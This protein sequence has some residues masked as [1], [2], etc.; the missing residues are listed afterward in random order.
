MSLY[1]DLILTETGLVSYWPLY[2]TSGTSAADLK[3]TNTGT[4][5]GNTPDVT[6]PTNDYD[7]SVSLNG[8]T[9]QVSCTDINALDGIS[10][11]TWEGWFRPAAIATNQTLFAK[12]LWQTQGHMSVV[13][14][15]TPPACQTIVFIA[16]TLTDG[17]TQFTNSNAQIMQNGQWTHLA[18]VYDGGLTNANR[19]KIYANNVAVAKTDTATIPTVL[20][21]GTA[22]FRIGTWEGL[23]RWWNGLSAR[24]AVYTVAL[25]QTQVTSHYQ[26]GM[27]PPPTHPFNAVPFT[28]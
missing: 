14:Q 2:E 6:S 10:T 25:T 24:V 27:T 13:N 20:T 11:M 15:G 23:G 1:T 5:A 28:R 26:L 9:G 8:T 12:W 21:S 17:G 22:Q 16:P 4:Y 7:G 19:I 3:G 18:I